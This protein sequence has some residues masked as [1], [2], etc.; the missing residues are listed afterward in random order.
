MGKL[1]EKINICKEE[2]ILIKKYAMGFLIPMFAFTMLVG[3]AQDEEDNTDTEAPV[4]EMEEEMDDAG[5]EVEE[6]L[7][8]DENQDETEKQEGE[9]DQDT[10]DPADTGNEDTME[11]GQ[12]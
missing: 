1:H 9:M 11:N 3:C 6:E 12:E 10:D 7:D 2:L 5:D 4:D 8:M